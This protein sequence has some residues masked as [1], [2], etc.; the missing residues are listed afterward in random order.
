MWEKEEEYGN[1]TW[2][3]TRDVAS[4]VNPMFGLFHTVGK[5]GEGVVS[6]AFGGGRKGYLLGKMFFD[7]IGGLAELFGESK[8]VQP[9]SKEQWKYEQDAFGKRLGDMQMSQQGNR[10]KMLLLSDEADYEEQRKTRRN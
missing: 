9:K 2:E 6:K 4:N 5:T 3:K 1:S 8:G 10:N 7:P